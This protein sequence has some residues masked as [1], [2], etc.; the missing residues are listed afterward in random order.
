[1]TPNDSTPGIL[2]FDHLL[3]KNHQIT[4]SGDPHAIDGHIDT[5]A[6]DDLVFHRLKNFR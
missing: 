4:G 3:D 2:A 6:P 1:M 5:F